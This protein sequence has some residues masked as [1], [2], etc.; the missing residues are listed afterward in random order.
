M[1]EKVRLRPG[2]A[3]AGKMSGRNLHFPRWGTKRAYG[4]G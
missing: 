4:S 1:A 2:T 3:G